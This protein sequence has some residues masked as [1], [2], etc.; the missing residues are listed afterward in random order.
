MEWVVATD[1]RYVQ[2]TAEQAIA[3]DLRA[4][5]EDFVRAFDGLGEAIQASRTILADSR[6]RRLRRHSTLR[7]VAPPD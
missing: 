4:T 1:G 6:R 3:V 7:L 2:L 5:V